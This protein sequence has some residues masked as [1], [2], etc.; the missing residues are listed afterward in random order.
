MEILR[1]ALDDVGLFGLCTISELK[2]CYNCYNRYN[3]TLNHC[4]KLIKAYLSDLK[5]CSKL[6]MVVAGCSRMDL[7][8]RVAAENRRFWALSAK[9]VA[10]VAGLAEIHI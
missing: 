1:C 6:Y 4:L 2:T 5:G 7:Y 3:L 8:N 10:V 9:V